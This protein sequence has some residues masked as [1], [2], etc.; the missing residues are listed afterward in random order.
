M[1]SDKPRR[2]PRIQQTA[3][4]VNNTTGPVTIRGV[5]AYD[6]EGN[7]VGRVGVEAPGDGDV[8]E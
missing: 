4:V 7:A 8:A 3:P 2:Q 5:T 6:E 1:A